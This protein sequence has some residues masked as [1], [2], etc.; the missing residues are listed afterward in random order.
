VP[1]GISRAPHGKARDRADAE[2]D[3]E[4][5][6]APQWCWQPKTLAPATV[7]RVP[8]AIVVFEYPKK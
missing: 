6:R 7:Y 4:L 8:G 5:T 2:V 1:R 3:I